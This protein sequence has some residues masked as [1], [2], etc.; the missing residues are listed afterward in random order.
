M[1]SPTLYDFNWDSNKAESN[2]KKHGASFLM[3]TSVFRDLRAIT[4][5]DE[6]HSDDEER[7]VSIGLAQNGQY[8]VIVHT[9]E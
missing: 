6:E 4:I 8:L 1:A 3:A 7:W 5:Y 2:F 9:N